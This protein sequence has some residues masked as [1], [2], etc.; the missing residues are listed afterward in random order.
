MSNKGYKSER[1]QYQLYF[2]IDKEKLKLRGGM[3]VA[4]ASEIAVKEAKRHFLA[5]GKS[6]AGVRIVARWRNPDNKN[7]LHANWKTSDDPGQSLEGFYKTITKR[8][9]RA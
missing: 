6:I 4:V 1:L 8:V 9:G 7:P 5:T 2:F 3:S